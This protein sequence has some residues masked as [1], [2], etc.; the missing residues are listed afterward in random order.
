MRSLV[1]VAAV[2]LA[3]CGQGVPVG[4]SAAG[5]QVQEVR[6]ELTGTATQTAMLVSPFDNGHVELTAT[7]KGEQILLAYDEWNE[8]APVGGTG[9]VV[10]FRMTIIPANADDTFSLANAGTQMGL[11]STLPLRASV[12][13]GQEERLV[14]FVDHVNSVTTQVP[15]AAFNGT[16]AISALRVEIPLLLQSATSGQP[17]LSQ[18][19]VVDLMPQDE[20]LRT[21]LNACDPSASQAATN[22]APAT[23]PPIQQPAAFVLS[24]VPNGAVEDG[25]GCLAVDAAG[26]NILVTDYSVG[27][28]QLNGTPVRLAALAGR[29]GGIDGTNFGDGDRIAVRVVF[30][31]EPTEAAHE[32]SATPANLVLSVDGSETVVPVSYRCES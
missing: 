22:A 12:Q 30:T 20:N 4:A 1:V 23:A 17:P 3:A 6:D 29:D 32:L 5:W 24:A 31:G 8:V 9:R 25:A 18:N 13:D 28:I 14:G 15:V 2:L 7:C 27:A 16:N 10:E 21:L 19:V 26:Q 11:E